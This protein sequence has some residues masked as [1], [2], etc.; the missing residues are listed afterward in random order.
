MMNYQFFWNFLAP[1]EKFSNISIKFN[2]LVFDVEKK[3]IEM[4]MLTKMI[5]I[6]GDSLM[7][8]HK[9]SIFS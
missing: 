8:S 5:N 9:S 7:P 1:S 6:S 2:K 3:Q 4:M